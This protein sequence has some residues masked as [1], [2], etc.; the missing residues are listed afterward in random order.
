MEVADRAQLPRLLDSV[1]PG[2]G[3]SDA[4]RLVARSGSAASI[5][6]DHRYDR[7]A[8]RGAMDGPALFRRARPSGAAVGTGAISVGPCGHEG[9]PVE[10]VS[11]CGCLK[12]ED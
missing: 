2:R 4:A 11:Y 5:V 3:D 8:R 1:V 10:N 6:G 7:D 12:Q 9:M